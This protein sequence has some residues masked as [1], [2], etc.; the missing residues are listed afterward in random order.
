MKAYIAMACSA[1]LLS[2]CYALNE[3]HYNS[4]VETPSEIESLKQSDEQMKQELRSIKDALSSMKT[5]MKSEIHAESVA[6]KQPTPESIQVIM[7]QQLMFASGSSEIS[8]A[9]RETLVKFANALKHAP[10]SAT[11]RIVGHTD[12]R[13]VGSKLKNKY[14][15][16]WALSTAR[17]AAVAR[18]LVWG[19]HL[20]PKRLHIEGSA[21]TQPI[22]SNAT[23]KGRA[24][25]RR[26]ELFVE[27]HS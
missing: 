9:G 23:E 13:P 22:A 4:V 8:S 6:V 7:Q 11:V 14:A 12:N 15:D 5:N 3:E 10:T 2:S 21:G 16:N 20:E 1:L 18:F 26:I 25:N 27:D 24:Q 17:A 19:A